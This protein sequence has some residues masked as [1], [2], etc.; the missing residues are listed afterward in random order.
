MGSI[1]LMFF[2]VGFSQQNTFWYLPL[3]NS[4]SSDQYTK[5]M[6]VMMNLQRIWRN[7][8]QLHS[9]RMRKYGDKEA[10]E[11]DIS[12]GGQRGSLGAPE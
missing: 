7:S 1:R 5:V 11:E 4:D 8:S 10:E 2:P 12:K 6:W 3:I 9:K